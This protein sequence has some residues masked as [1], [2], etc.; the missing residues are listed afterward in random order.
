[1]NIFDKSK[2]AE[3][4]IKLNDEFFIKIINKEKYNNITNKTSFN[5]NIPLCKFYYFLNGTIDKIY[6]PEEMNEFYKSAMIDLIEKITPKLS[7]SLYQNKDNKRRLQNIQK[8]KT[9]LNYEKIVKNDALEKIIIYE[10]KIQ[11]DFNEKK[12]YQILK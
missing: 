11:K 5:E 7:K 3:E 4:L 6:F 10:D 9:K 2:S 1:M 12:M 8:D